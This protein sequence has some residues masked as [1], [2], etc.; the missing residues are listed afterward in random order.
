MGNKRARQLIVLIILF[1]VTGLLVYLPRK[2][3]PAVQKPS[4]KS[5]LAEINQYNL[6][7]YIEIEDKIYKFLDLDDYIF[8]DYLGPDGKVNLFIG[9]YYSA[10]KV[11]AAHSPLAC[12][13]GQGWTISQ[14]SRYQ[15]KV[16]EF[17]IKYE[18]ITATLNEQKELV[19]YW[20][21]AGGETTPQIY[22]NKINTLYNKIKLDDEQHAFVRITV[23]LA[24]SS[25][26]E[27]K[28]KGLAF[29]SSFFPTFLNFVN[30]KTA[31][32]P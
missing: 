1:F 8:A 16:G 13:P 18:E 5:R 12:F 14:P 31:S 3:V 11:S 6:V 30:E 28:K 10:D 15:V 24:G 7:R 17:E 20:Y 32:L 19:M 9:F 23:P 2:P 21:Q 4:L 29:M 27:A 26:D 25:Y 22:R